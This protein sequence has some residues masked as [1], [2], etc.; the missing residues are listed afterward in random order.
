M[1]GTL[2]YRLL[3]P[4]RH[5]YSFIYSAPEG[6]KAEYFSLGRKE[7]AP[8]LKSRQSR[9]RTGDLVMERQRTYQLRQPRP[10]IALKGCIAKSS[11]NMIH[12]IP[13]TE[14]R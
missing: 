7:E 13:T 12:I 6:W 5:W 11:H 3:A 1:D 4:S 8:M 2:I 14:Q 9:N 10:P